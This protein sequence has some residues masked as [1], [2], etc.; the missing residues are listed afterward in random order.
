MANEFTATGKAGVQK[1]NAY[2]GFHCVDGK[3]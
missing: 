2:N 1:G 3:S